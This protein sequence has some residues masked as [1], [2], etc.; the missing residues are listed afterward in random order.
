MKV[1][2]DVL[3][4]RPWILSRKVA[5][6]YRDG[7]VFLLV[8]N[9]RTLFHYLQLLTG[10]LFLPDVEMRLMPFLLQVA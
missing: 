9:E 7:Q 3:S 1:P 6:S 4:Y 2:Y 5:H 10:L 8:Q